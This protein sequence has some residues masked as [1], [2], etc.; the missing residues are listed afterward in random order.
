MKACIFIFSVVS[1]SA[2]FFFGCKKN[3]GVDF[4]TDYYPVKKGKYIIYQVQDIVIDDEVNQYDTTNV[5]IKAIIGD[6]FVDN[7]GRVANRYERWFGPTASG[8]WT[9]IDIWTTIVA[10]NRAEL[11]EENNRTIKLVFAPTE[12]KTWNANTY[13]TLEE[14]DSYYTDIHVPYSIGGHSFDSTLTVLQQYVEPNLIQYKNKYERYA[15][16][17]GMIQKVYVDELHQNFDTL[18]VEKARKL[19]MNMVSYG[20]E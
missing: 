2:F 9:L 5:F 19:Y 3:E 13:N 14:L 6:T 17:V 18:Q 15:K 12:Y 16:G 1:L 10:N 7:E 8:P 4:H 11:V 20:Q